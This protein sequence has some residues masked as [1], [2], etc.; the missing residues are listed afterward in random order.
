MAALQYLDFELKIERVGDQYQATVVR[1]PVGEASHLFDLP[2][3]DLELENL[4]LRLGASHRGMRR[5]SSPEM[6]RAR[7]FGSRLF[8]AVFR[9]DVRAGFVSSQHEAARR[10]LGLRLKLRLDAPELI[11]VPWEYLYDDSLGRFL[12][13]F[14]HTPIVR[15][16]DMRGLIAPLQVTSPLSVLVM[17]SAP[18]DRPA[19]DVERERA[20]LQSAL[21]GLVDTG[22]LTLTLVARATLPALADCLLRGS[23]HVFHYIGHGAFDE[24]SQDGVLVLEDD[25][26]RGLLTSGERLAVLLGNHPTLRLVLLNAC[27][28]ART[29]R[30]DPFAGTATTLVQTA[31]VPAVV[32]MQLPIT[33]EAAITFGRGFYTALSVGRPVDASVTHARLAVFAEGNDVEWG[34]PVLYMRAPDGRIFDVESLALETQDTRQPEAEVAQAERE[35]VERQERQEQQERQEVEDRAQRE[36]ETRRAESAGEPAAADEAA[37]AGEPSPP[38]GRRPRPSGLPE[39][40][41]PRHKPKDLP[42]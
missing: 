34:K 33:D 32:A 36:A 31:G 11:N 13:L 3:S 7:Q 24:H 27:E 21:S 10:G 6:E 4:I 30:D 9:G 23:Y 1:S 29:A 19:L 16:I 14:E 41:K 20:N 8:E 22:M 40:I 5:I 2:F 15:Y 26:G 39:E 35:V 18:D 37:Q 38:A 42:A 17:I 25:A 12:S 28:G